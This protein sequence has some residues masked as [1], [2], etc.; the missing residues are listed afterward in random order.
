[1]QKPVGYYTIGNAAV[2]YFFVDRSKF[3]SSIAS[4]SPLPLIS[5]MAGFTSKEL[6]IKASFSATP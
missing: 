4:I 3:S 2:Y 6:R 1:M 5:R